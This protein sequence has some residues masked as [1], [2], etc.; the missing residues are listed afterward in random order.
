[1][2]LN[3]DSIT[4]PY[5]HGTFAKLDISKGL[6]IWQK[7]IHDVLSLNYFSNFIV[8]NTNAQ[9][10]VALSQE[11]GQVAWTLDLLEPGQ[12]KSYNLLTPI[13]FNDVINV[14]S[15]QSKLYQISPGGALLKEI[16]IPKGA[17]FY[18]VWRQ[19]I[20]LFAGKNI[21]IN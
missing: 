2:L 16:K 11:T 17:A 21:W 5:A 6:P 1:M 15:S 9:Q 7:S 14:F 4:L 10:V 3:S 18:G 8:L 12:K 19:D 20:Y 13:M